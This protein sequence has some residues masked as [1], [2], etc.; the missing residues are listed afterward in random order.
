MIRSVARVS[1]RL[2]ATRTQATHLSTASLVGAR[3]LRAF[4]TSSSPSSS[5]ASSSSSSPT[6]TSTAL[7]PASSAPAP[8]NLRSLRRDLSRLLDEDASDLAS[9]PDPGLLEFIKEQ[10]YNHARRTL[11]LLSEVQAAELR[12]VSRHALARV[13]SDG[14]VF[15]LPG[16]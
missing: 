1:A 3:L 16:P 8:S 4:A 15:S 12:F 14:G 6:S 13:D 10:R 5:A 7:S 11:H 9:A 2:A